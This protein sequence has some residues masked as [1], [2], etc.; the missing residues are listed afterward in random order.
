MF[1][2]IPGIRTTTISTRTH[3][4][5]Q[6]IEIW[7]TQALV[8][9]HDDVTTMMITIFLNKYSALTR[10]FNYYIYMFI[11]NGLVEKYKRQFFVSVREKVDTKPKILK[12]DRLYGCFELLLIGYSLAGAAFAWELWQGTERRKREKLIQRKGRNCKRLVPKKI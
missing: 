7:K 2:V 11:E 5:Y 9:T 3:I 12:L 6:N 1:T 10:L 4:K 8:P